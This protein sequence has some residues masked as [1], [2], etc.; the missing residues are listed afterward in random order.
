[1]AT[2]SLHH[3]HHRLRAVSNWLEYLVIAQPDEVQLRDI[4]TGVAEL[5]LDG[6]ERDLFAA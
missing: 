5:A 6:V 4:Q 3:G 2:A 1:M